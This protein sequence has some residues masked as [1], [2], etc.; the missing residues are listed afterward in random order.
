MLAVLL[1][2]KVGFRISKDGNGLSASEKSHRQHRQRLWLGRF[3]QRFSGNWPSPASL[4]ASSR[5]RLVALTPDPSPFGR[6]EECSPFSQRKEEK[7]SRL[8][9]TKTRRMGRTPDN[10]SVLIHSPLAP[11][12]QMERGRSEGFDLFPRNPL[13]YFSPLPLGE[14]SGVRGVR[15]FQ[16]VSRTASVSRRTS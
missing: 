16:I 8:E 15:A 6:G 9:I 10:E 2:R 14:G 7:C 1:F 11:L 12:S 4:S 13:L 3:F 5:G